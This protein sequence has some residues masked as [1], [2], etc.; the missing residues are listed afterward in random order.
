M[1]QIQ[2]NYGEGWKDTVYRPM[3]KFSA[4]TI[5]ERLQSQYTE[6]QYRVVNI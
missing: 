5:T 4:Q 6:Y 3:D 2:I 1:V